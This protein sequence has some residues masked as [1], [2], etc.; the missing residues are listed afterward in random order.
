ML[1]I[2]QQVAGQVL[3]VAAL[4]VRVRGEP[5]QAEQQVL[6]AF[7]T[8]ERKAAELDRRHEALGADCADLDD[9]VSAPHAFRR[10]RGLSRELDEVMM[11]TLLAQQ[12]EIVAQ[13]AVLAFVFGKVKAVLSTLAAAA[14]TDRASGA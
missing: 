13:R 10:A 14:R 1:K 3:E 2:R 12:E 5:A 9:G 7:Q 8:P 11:A 4:V 6:A